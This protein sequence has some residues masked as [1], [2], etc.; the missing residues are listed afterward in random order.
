M[1]NNK[2]K[3]LQVMNYIN[4]LF[5]PGED[6]YKTQKLVRTLAENE[7]E[8]MIKHLLT[9]KEPLYVLFP[10]NSCLELIWDIYNPKGYLKTKVNKSLLQAIC[11][12]LQGEEVDVE[13]LDFTGNN[14][15]YIAEEEAV[16]YLNQ[17]LRASTFKLIARTYSALGLVKYNAGKRG[18]IHLIFSFEEGCTIDL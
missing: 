17:R 12:K 10:L 8:E 1:A 2:F 5:I 13:N 16:N 6:F 3:N 15:R 7:K 4:K 18:F 14:T 11:N 9:S